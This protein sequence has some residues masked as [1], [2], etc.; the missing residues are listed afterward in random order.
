[1][2]WFLCGFALRCLHSTCMA[3]QGM[4]WYTRRLCL[5]RRAAQWEDGRVDWLLFF[6][7]LF[8]FFLSRD[9]KRVSCP[10]LQT[11]RNWRGALGGLEDAMF[12]HITLRLAHFPLLPNC[13]SAG[14]NGWKATQPYYAVIASGQ[15]ARRICMH[16]GVCCLRAFRPFPS[17]RNSP[18]SIHPSPDTGLGCQPREHLPFSNYPL[19]R[20]MA[21]TRLG[22]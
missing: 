7:C 21:R 8:L 3:W 19:H 1:M 12:A 2:V 15:R 6:S 22:R 5:V 14:L 16:L 11:G 10:R 4:A 17:P 18:S 13:L 20:D 9:T